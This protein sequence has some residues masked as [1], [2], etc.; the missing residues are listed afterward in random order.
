VEHLGDNPIVTQIQAMKKRMEALYSES[1]EGGKQTEKDQPKPSDEPEFFEPPVDLWEAGKEWF[2]C[3]DLP[4]VTDENV[5]VELIEDKLTIR[6]TRKTS[7]VGE[8]LEA[9]QTECPEGAF[10]RTFV[11]PEKTQEEAIKAELKH[12]ILTLTI[13]KDPGSSA[14][15][16][17]V[18]VR[19]G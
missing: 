2:I 14:A 4:G 19:A 7:L 5:Q 17:K 16:Q 15:S 6:G 12:G 9:V 13:F 8:G 3:I 18:Q 11:L 10:S 1:F